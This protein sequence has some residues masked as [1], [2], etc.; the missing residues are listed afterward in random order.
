MV[1]WLLAHLDSMA[2]VE[3]ASGGGAQVCLIVG[4]RAVARTPSSFD[5]G[6]RQWHG[7]RC[8]ACHCWGEDG[9][10]GPTHPHG[11]PP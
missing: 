2:A 6:Q 7:P 1:A 10:R 5:T 8:G 9:T 4:G 3:L 11:R